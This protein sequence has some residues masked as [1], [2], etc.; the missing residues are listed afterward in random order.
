MRKVRCIGWISNDNILAKFYSRSIFVNS[1]I[2]EALPMPPLEAMACK[3]AVITS[4]I[5]GSKEF[6]IEGSNCL[7]F[8]PDSVDGLIENINIL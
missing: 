6:V 3:S 7:S 1:G 5:P 4:S 2:N 8:A